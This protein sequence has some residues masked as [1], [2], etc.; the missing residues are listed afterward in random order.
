MK[1]VKKET[2]SDSIILKADASPAEVSHAFN[3]AATMFANQ[4][5]V[6]I[7][8]TKPALEQVKSQV[9]VPDLE[10]ILK[11]QTIESL[12]P[13]AVDKS[14]IMPASKPTTRLEADI[15]NGKPFSFEVRLTP[16]PEYELSSYDPVSITIPPYTFPE[17]QLDAMMKRMA[18]DYAEY[19]S[20]DPHPVNSGDAVKIALH[21]SVDGQEMTNINTDGRTYVLGLGM[22]PAE[23]DK[24][25]IGMNVGEEKDFS[26]ALPGNPGQVSMAQC[27]VTILEM[28]KKVV[29]E[30]DDDW[31]AKYMPFYRNADALRGAMRQNLETDLRRQYEQSKAS[32]AATEIA[33]RFEGKIPDHIYEGSRETLIDNLQSELQQQGITLDQFIA[34]SGGHEQ[35]GM[36][37]MF[38]VRQMLIEGY[39]LDAVFRHEKMHLDDEDIDIACRDMNPVDPIGF[40]R[41]MEENG[42][43][44]TLREAASRSK[45]SR[46]LAEN[47][48]ITIDES[49]SM[50]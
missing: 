45:A 33:K 48:N 2:K 15:E 46:F 28:Q 42:F 43:G 10:A 38:Q 13:F 49:L 47:A 18:E 23:F 34:Q 24:E 30:V 7:D 5:G 19:V 40:R 12:M 1:V 27:K 29:A 4:M 26:F 31:V 25:L 22:L 17:D 37:L 35:F 6:Q 14:G 16:K 41:R 9:N 44:Y 21:M 20:D 32:M 36:M 39:S 8:A 3:T 50:M 11:R